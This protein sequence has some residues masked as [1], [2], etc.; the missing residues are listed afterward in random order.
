MTHLHPKLNWETFQKA[1][2]RRKRRRWLFWLTM[3]TTVACLAGLVVFQYGSSDPGT[4]ALPSA[5]PSET[6][7]VSPAPTPPAATQD[8][9][10]LPQ[11]NTP[12]DSNA[13]AIAEVNPSA[14]AQRGTAAEALTAVENR[15]ATGQTEPSP[16]TSTAVATVE[17]AAT[18][19]GAASLETAATAPAVPAS[20]AE[21]VLLPAGSHSPFVLLENMDPLRVPLLP[22]SRSPL[23]LL[24]PVAPIPMPLARDLATK[25]LAKPRATTLWLTLAWSPW[26][27]RE[28]ERASLSAD[29]L[30]YRSLNSVNVGLRWEIVGQN[31]WF[32]AL[33]PQFNQQRFQLQYEGVFADARY[34]PGSV[35]GYQQTAKG[36]EPIVA[37]SVPGLTTLT[38]YENGQQT[39]ISLPVTLS[40]SIPVRGPL[41][42]R[43]TAGLGMNYRAAYRGS[44]VRSER[45]ISLSDTPTQLGILASGGL[46]LVYQPGRI[47]YACLVQSTYRSTVRA[48]QRPLR[49]QLWFSVALPLVR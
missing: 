22:S 10:V 12:R 38:Q 5:R 29:K 15:A 27:S 33:E 30:Q 48:D 35:I 11:E 26:H 45:P 31:A 7:A 3:A 28:F 40:R 18:P 47:R 17:A 37:D 49:N 9:V 14:T 13:H 23:Q 36:F 41:S 32:V 6:T 24:P 8:A 19:A 16:E 43:A 2:A 42:L 20:P 39:E 46:S 21:L 1:R 4:N 44:W 34:A 25:D